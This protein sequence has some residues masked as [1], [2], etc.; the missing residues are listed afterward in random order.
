MRERL[1]LAQEGLI[2][3]TRRGHGMGAHSLTLDIV[4]EIL[5]EQDAGLLPVISHYRRLLIM[6][7]RPVLFRLLLV[8]SDSRW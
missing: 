4:V 5:D 3:L 2:W 6:W 7:A 8:N 1:T